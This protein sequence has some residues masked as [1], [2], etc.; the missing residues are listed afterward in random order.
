MA[1]MVAVDD[2]ERAIAD[3]A[4]A[5]HAAGVQAPDR[6]VGE[7]DHEVVWQVL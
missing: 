6:L 3:A 1:G 5:P 4:R 7:G 2:D